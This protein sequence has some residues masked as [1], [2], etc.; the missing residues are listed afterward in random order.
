MDIDLD[1]EEFHRS[2]DMALVTYLKME[3][4]THQAVRWEDR[5]CF[6]YFRNTDGIH[7]MID[8]FNSGRATVNPKEYNKE[9]TATKR[10]FYDSRDEHQ[11]AAR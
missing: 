3:G 11:H 9:F 8:E 7:D 5:T 4:Y 2:N 10:E 1:P 6:W